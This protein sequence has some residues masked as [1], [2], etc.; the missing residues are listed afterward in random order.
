MFVCFHVICY[1]LF[2]ICYLVFGILYVIFQVRPPPPL[3]ARVDG[4]SDNSSTLLSAPAPRT[5][6]FVNLPAEETPLS[7][8][9]RPQA[10][11]ARRQKRAIALRFVQQLSGS[12][13]EPLALS[14]I[15]DDPDEE[16]DIC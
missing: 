3:P 9:I 2:F 1:L 14:D 11:D 16:D 13:L 6:P 15:S 4:I 8:P 10:M 7:A 12:T 5:N